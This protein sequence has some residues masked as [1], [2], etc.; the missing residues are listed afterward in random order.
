[1]L[2]TSITRLAIIVGYILRD[3]YIS[4]RFTMIKFQGYKTSLAMWIAALP[5]SFRQQVESGFAQHCPQDI[6]HAT[7]NTCK[8]PTT[9]VLGANIYLG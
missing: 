3:V 8:G 2:Q 1:V 9:S 7:V 6:R 4:G 5:S